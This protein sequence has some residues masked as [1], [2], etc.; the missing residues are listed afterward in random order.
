MAASYDTGW[1][2]GEWFTNSDPADFY[3]MANDEPAPPGMRHWS[4]QFSD[5]EQ[6]MRLWGKPRPRTDVVMGPPH[7][8]KWTVEELEDMGLIGIYKIGDDVEPDPNQRQKLIAIDIRNNRRE[9]ADWILETDGRRMAE[10]T[11]REEYDAMFN[12]IAGFIEDGQT[13]GM[14]PFWELKTFND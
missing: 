10:Y 14:C 2:D 7:P 13:K 6:Q 3:E 4:H 11:S 8:G 9:G 5:Q 12:R 1:E